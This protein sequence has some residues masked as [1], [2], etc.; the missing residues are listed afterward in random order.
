MLAGAPG[1][2]ERARTPS[3]A[4]S[5]AGDET[6]SYLQPVPG[7]PANPNR[8]RPLEKEFT[9]L[10]RRM[11]GVLL[12]DAQR[13]VSLLSSFRARGQQGWGVWSPGGRRARPAATVS[14]L[15]RA[16]A[17]ILGAYGKALVALCVMLLTGPKQQQ[18]SKIPKVQLS[19]L[20]AGRNQENKHVLESFWFTGWGGEAGTDCKSLLASA[21]LVW[22]ISRWWLGDL[23]GLQLISRWRKWLLWKGDNI[24]IPN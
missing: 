2:A 9:K 13:F 17:Q 21:L 15:D 14:R 7:S 3:R 4:L 6:A 19:T 20:A 12:P 24:V 5:L 18:A 1:E 10:G 8:P 23:L 11:G 16:L 22:P